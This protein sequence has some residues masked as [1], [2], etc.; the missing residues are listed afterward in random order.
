MIPK[1]AAF[2]DLELPLYEPSPCSPDISAID[3]GQGVVLAAPSELPLYSEL[4]P[5]CGGMR[6]SAPTMVGLGREPIEAVVVLLTDLARNRMTSLNLIPDKT[7]EPDDHPP[8]DPNDFPDTQIHTMFFGVDLFSFHHGLRA[9]LRPGP[10]LLFAVV[11]ELKSD[12]IT[13]RVVDDDDTSE[14]AQP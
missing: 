12:S 6:L 10:L 7:P 11:G 4:F 3:P 14:G 8:G 1:D 13:V 9:W 5:L 2:F